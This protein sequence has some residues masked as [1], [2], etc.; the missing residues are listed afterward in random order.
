LSIASESLP[1]L[2][3]RPLRAAPNGGVTRFRTIWISDTHLGMRGCK[4]EAL[5]DFLE[6]TE[7]ECLY[8]V[9]DI[10]DGWR[11]R[12][13]WYWPRSHNDVVQH[14]LRKAHS[15]T[16]VVYL[17]G[18][19]DEMM[20]DFVHLRFGGVTITDETV[21]ETA[22]GRRFL[23]I[24]GDQFDG[25]LDYAGGLARVGDKVYRLAMASNRGLNFVRRKMGYPYWSLSAYLKQKVKDKART[26]IRYKAA[27]SEEARRHDVDGIICGHIH[28]PE[29]SDLDGY[30]YCN[31]G[32]W[33]EACTAL[34]EHFDG[35]LELV[36]WAEVRQLSLFETRRW[37]AGR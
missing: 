24:H 26:V 23:V 35:R 12:K 20:R 4:V 9:G 34:V 14:L 36:P 17:P 2:R 16:R 29:M 15:G 1:R 10:I 21:H 25:I 13:T 3:E 32:D 19:H 7:S 30:L 8:L 33:V 31:A 27:L 11:L 22:D 28:Q 37:R 18:N 6:H 5:L